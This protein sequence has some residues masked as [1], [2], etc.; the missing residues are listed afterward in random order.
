MQLF[1]PAT[2]EAIA[3]ATKQL[4]GLFG[5]GAIPADLT[6]FWG[7]ADGALGDVAVVYSTKDIVP[8]NK[9]LD[10]C[11][12]SPGF[13]AIGDDAGGVV[14]YLRLG[15]TNRSVY[16]NYERDSR[17]ETMRNLDMSLNDWVEAECPFDTPE[18]EFSAA[19]PVSVRIDNLDGAS[20][21]E[22]LRM[23]ETLAPGTSLK[24]F[25]TQLNDLPVQLA[26][27][28]YCGAVDVCAKLAALG[29][30]V[31]IWSVSEPARQ[32]PTSYVWTNKEFGHVDSQGD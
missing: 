23:R 20:I 12:T 1:A 11:V 6:K 18:P 13:V 16:L 26:E 9:L 8:I 22:I 7:I 5:V 29:C 21:F 15:S 19:D 28:S 2:C 31:S 17:P 30:R 27:N 3:Q 32:F 10:V 25:R 24:E 14:A 4:E